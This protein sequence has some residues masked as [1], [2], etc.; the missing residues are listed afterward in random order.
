MSHAYERLP[1]PLAGASHARD[2]GRGGGRRPLAAARQLAA[3][4]R[5]R[6]RVVLN[7]PSRQQ[8]RVLR[9]HL[10]IR[11]AELAGE[12]AAEGDIE[13]LEA[14]VAARRAPHVDVVLALILRL[15]P[16]D[17]DRHAERRCRRHRQRLD[18]V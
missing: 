3:P 13:R 17:L 7:S 11:K 18:G 15:R 10:L 4:A 2:A 16:A 12:L 5:G 6:Q 1:R 8:R 9:E 14:P